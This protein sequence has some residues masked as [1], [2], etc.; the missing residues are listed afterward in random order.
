[1]IKVNVRFQAAAV[2]LTAAL[3]AAAHPSPSPGPGI[4]LTLAVQNRTSYDLLDSL[5]I[6]VVAHNPGSSMRLVT[7]PGPDE[8]QIEVFQ[9]GNPIYSYP[10]PRPGAT[11]P[12]HQRAFTPGPTTI[13]TNAWNEL[14]SG[15]WSPK[16]GTYKIR[17]RVLTAGPSPEASLEVTFGAPLP[18][19]ALPALHAGE[20]V[21]L[22]G[23]LDPTKFVLTDPHGSA[24][25]AHKLLTAPAGFPIVVRGYAADHP[26]G[27]R[28]FTVV[29]WAPYGGPPPV[30]PP[31]PP[32]GPMRTMIPRPLPKP[33]PT[34]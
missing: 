11:F 21:T 7:F 28:A 2:A 25:L 3:L 24:L 9:D 27:T 14:T 15:G 31:A 4:G 16:P 10:P 13:V 17:A 26:D 8:Y 29:R 18:P 23:E 5:P 33:T 34:S 30:P 32:L 19:G 22:L 12:P 6:S 20:Q 1:M